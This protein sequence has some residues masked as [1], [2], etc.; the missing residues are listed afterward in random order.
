MVPA[1]TWQD[2]D[3]NGVKTAGAVAQ[4]IE[5]R[6]V[7]TRLP[8]L[9]THR[10]ADPLPLAIPYTSERISLVIGNYDNFYC[11]YVSTRKTGL[12]LL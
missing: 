8:G 9:K 2:A 12:R 5:R 11:R 3:S 10:A 4:S 7:A 1:A 6:R